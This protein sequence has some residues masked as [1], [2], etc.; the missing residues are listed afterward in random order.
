MLWIACELLV[1]SCFYFILWNILY[2]LVGNHFNVEA[3][4]LLIGKY[5]SGVVEADNMRSGIVVWSCSNGK[6]NELIY[7]LHL[8][9]FTK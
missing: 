8:R 7:L 9:F 1:H 4:G 3:T 2:L 6:T 5:T